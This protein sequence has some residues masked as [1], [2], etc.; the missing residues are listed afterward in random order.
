VDAALSGDLPKVQTLLEEGANIEAT[1][2]DGLTALDA[3]AKRGH[4]DVLQYLI[5]RG[6]AVNGTSSD[7]RTA[8][9]LAA[10]YEHTE[11]ARFLVS[12]GGEIRGSAEWKQ[13]LLASLKRDGK[14]DL[15]Q[16][17]KDQIDR[18]RSTRHS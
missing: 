15:Y 1:A 12:K 2:Y 10:V 18:E 14:D 8:L 4:L 13:D 7:K 11:C 17:V 16:I 5:V 3:A 6:A 9:G